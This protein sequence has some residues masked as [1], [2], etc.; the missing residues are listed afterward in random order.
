[1]KPNDFPRLTF[2]LSLPLHD[3]L[4]GSNRLFLSFG[5]QSLRIQCSL[6]QRLRRPGCCQLV[7]LRHYKTVVNSKRLL[8]GVR[9]STCRT[10]SRRKSDVWL[11]AFF[12]TAVDACAQRRAGRSRCDEWQRW[13]AKAINLSPGFLPFPRSEGVTAGD[14]GHPHC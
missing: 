4:P 6:A 1:M 10:L 7:I 14:H 12:S 3:A 13:Q 5:G 2:E 8:F 9:A 11:D